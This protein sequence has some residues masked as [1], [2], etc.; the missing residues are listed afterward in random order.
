MKKH[1]VYIFFFLF[2]PVILQAK[3]Y[4]IKEVPNVRHTDI[5]YHVSDPEKILSQEATDS[6][7]AKL[8]QLEK[9]TGIE[10]AVVVLPSI[11]SEDSFDFAYELGEEWG[12]GKKKN[13][14][15]LVIL[16]VI[17]QRR[18]QIATG[19]GIEGDLP[20]AICKRIQ[21]KY[22]IPSFKQ[23]DWSTGLVKGVT[24]ICGKLD[25]SMKAD[26]DNEEGSSLDFFLILAAFV[27]TIIF[28]AVASNRKAKRCPN[29]HKYTLQ[30]TDSELIGMTAGVKM[31]WVT[32][33]CSN[34]GRKVV[35]KQSHYDEN[36]HGHGFGGPFIGGFWGGGNGG[37]GGG[38]SGG[39]FGGG[40]FGGGGA[41]S[42][43]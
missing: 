23:G 18:I 16:L 5:R 4:T 40:S 28:T 36:D 37:G 41:G 9:K 8:Y 43:F 14:N 21:M 33:T 11:G 20:D 29:C 24:S 10:T 32:Y 15:G 7:D 31:E 30:R 38:F 25:G 17:D 19:K 27:G 39:S 22:M 26:D 12:I 35:R 2:V 42:G 13:D 3:S 34:C 6:I 1:L